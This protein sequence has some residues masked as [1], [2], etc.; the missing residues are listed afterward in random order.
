M[1]QLLLKIA[2]R[3]PNAHIF[4]AG[5][6]DIVPASSCSSGGFIGRADL[7]L[8][9]PL[10]AD[11]NNHIAAAV[12]AVVGMTGQSITFVDVTEAFTGHEPCTDQAFI[13]GMSLLDIKGSFHPNA[14]GQCAYAH[15]VWSA[16]RE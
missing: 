8:L 4:M 11:L 10:I 6:P 13:Q 2:A 9:R 16:M 5:Y 14:L 12:E 1:T 3:A 7:N 15:Q